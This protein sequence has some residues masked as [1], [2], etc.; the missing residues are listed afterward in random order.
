MRKIICLLLI[1]LCCLTTVGCS[2]PG[3]ANEDTVLFYYPRSEFRYG[4]PDGVLLCEQRNMP[5]HGKD[6]T[7]IISMYLLGPETEALTLPF[8]AHTRLLTLDSKENTLVITLSDTQDSFA[9]VQY[10]L[11]CACLAKTCMEVSDAEVFTIIAG[12]H[13]LTLHRDSVCFFDSS[14]AETTES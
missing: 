12:S 9:D 1:L 5:G 2:F 3:S 14:T 11:A 13:F 7:Y 8:P 4:D 6:L 10:T